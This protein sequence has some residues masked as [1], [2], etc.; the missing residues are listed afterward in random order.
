MVIG[1]FVSISFAANL[2]FAMIVVSQRPNKKD[3]AFYWSP[4][5]LYELVPVVLSLAGA[6]AVPFFAY[7][8]DFMFILLIPHILVF[9]PCLLGPSDSSSLKTTKDQKDKATPRYATLLQWIAATSVIMQAYFTF[10]MLQDLDPNASFGKVVQ[11]LWNAIYVH[12]ACSSVSWDVILCT[13][14]AFFWALVHGFDS[15]R[16]LGSL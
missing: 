13:T 7:E 14:T 12:P 2:F 5:L 1:Q 11:W 16:M 15:S 4:P 8:K 9:V 3:T 6:G 10:L